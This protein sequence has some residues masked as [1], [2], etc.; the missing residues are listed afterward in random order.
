VGPDLLAALRPLAP[1]PAAP[2][3]VLGATG[4]VVL[5]N[6]RAQCT[7]DAGDP[8]PPDLPAHAQ[9]DCLSFELAVDGRRVV[10]DPGTTTYDG[11]QRAWERS[12]SAH[13]TV[14]IDGANQTEVW[15]SFRAGR[16]APAHLDHVE[17]G[18]N[19]L[20]V[21]HHTGYAVLPGAPIHRRHTKFGKAA[22]V[23]QC[24][25][26]MSAASLGLTPARV[27]CKGSTKRP[28]LAAR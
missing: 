18:E 23:S 13:N 16:L 24:Q 26:R 12:T 3:T 2:V 8:C 19:P 6:G 9:A 5:R 7:I 28:S 4:Y 10:V 1:D 22:A 14:T 21:A 27:R 11:A 15:G 25:S 20:V 17:T